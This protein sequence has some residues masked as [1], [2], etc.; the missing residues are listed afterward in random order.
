M[1]IALFSGRGSIRDFLV[2][3]DNFK[4]S[5]N[6]NLDKSNYSSAESAE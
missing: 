1:L 3:H 2:E 4:M 6:S 5:W